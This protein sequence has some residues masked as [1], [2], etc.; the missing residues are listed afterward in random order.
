MPHIVQRIV[1]DF[2]SACAV[3]V[4]GCGLVDRLKLG[5]YDIMFTLR[6]LT[7]RRLRFAH[8]RK[9]SLCFHG[10]MFTYTVLHKLDL[11]LLRVILVEK[12]YALAIDRDPKVIF[13]LGSNVGVTLVYFAAMFPNAQIYSFE[14]DPDNVR[15]LE[16]HISTFKD[17]VHFFPKAVSAEHGGTINLFPVEG[18]HW[19][20]S[21]VQKTAGSKPFHVGTVSLDRVMAEA[22]IEHIDILKFDIEGAEYD[23]FRHFAGLD[24]VQYLIGEVHPRLFGRSIEDFLDLFP[25]FEVIMSH[26]GSKHLTVALKNLKKI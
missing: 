1:T 13:D 16:Q 24:H 15:L 25:G 9:V 17:R 5:T 8:P 12:E 22:G 19:S 18:R 26:I 23:V 11:H 7:G 21:I 4:L 20:T 10:I 3:S 6:D 14:P 2:R